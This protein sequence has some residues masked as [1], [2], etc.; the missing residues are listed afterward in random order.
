MDKS[1]VT[2]SGIPSSEKIKL[3]IIPLVNALNYSKKI[4]TVY[5]GTSL[6]TETSKILQLKT[7]PKLQSQYK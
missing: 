4:P 6:K 3:P 7:Q 5:S 1:V 2:Q